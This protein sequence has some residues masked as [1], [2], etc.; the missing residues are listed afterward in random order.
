MGAAA[1]E[2]EAAAAMTYPRAPGKSPSRRARGASGD[3]D[4]WHPLS[5]RVVENC[6]LLALAA[7][8]GIVAY[9][10][11]ALNDPGFDQN[12][13]NQMPVGALAGVGAAIAVAA[14]VSV[15]VF[16]G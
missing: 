3:P 2:E 8:W 5:R 1:K 11:R 15:A 9:A 16:G 14:G 4:P 7:A 6:L 13:V 10:R 12:I